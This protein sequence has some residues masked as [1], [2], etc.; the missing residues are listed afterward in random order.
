MQLTINHLTA[1]RY[2]QEV[3]RSTQTI[4]LTPRDSAGQ[5]VLEWKLKLPAPGLELVDAFDNLTHLL[6]LDKPHQEIRIA[7]TGRVEVAEVDD[8]EPAGHLNP[9][10]FLRRTRLTEPDEALQAFAAPMQSMMRARPL[11]GASDLFRAVLERVPAREG[12]TTAETTAAQAF[13]LRGGTGQDQAHVFITCCRLLGVPARYVSGYGYQPQGEQLRTKAWAE[14]WVSHR[15]VCLDDDS[16][17]RVRI[18]HGLDYLDACPVRGIRLG[19]GREELS[20]RAD[21]SLA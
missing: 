21:V 15:W 14:A 3:Y 10:I 8:G 5:K 1:Y 17:R 4:R 20:T 9:R 18:A 6:T 11:I 16:Q 19:G 13:E 2:E 12:L 7:A